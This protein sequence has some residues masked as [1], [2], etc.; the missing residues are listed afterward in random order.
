[1]ALAAVGMQAVPAPRNPAAQG[2]LLVLPPPLPQVS[3]NFQL[4]RASRVVPGYHA[5]WDFR[6][7]WLRRLWTPSL[8]VVYLG[9]RCRAGSCYRVSMN[10]YVC[11]NTLA[12]GHQPSGQCRADCI[13]CI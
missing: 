6:S 9:S 10:F 8:L 2:Q 1:M 7:V 4:E 3:D 11:R 12:Y 13:S 5:C